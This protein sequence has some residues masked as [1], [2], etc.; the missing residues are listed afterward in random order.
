LPIDSHFVSQLE[1]K[2]E[3]TRLK[4][5]DSDS[6]ENLIPKT[7]QIESVLS[8][9]QK[10]QVKGLFESAV[11]NPDMEI[12]VEGMHPEELPVTITMDEF[13][14]RMKDMAK[15]GGGMMGMYGSFPDRYKVTVNG[16][17]KLIQ[18]LLAETDTTKQK[19]MARQAFDLALLSRNML[20]GEALTAFV[21]RSVGM[22]R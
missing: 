1:Q 7:E 17:H 14:R 20:T 2:L 6:T 8:D 4:R 19:D 21:N 13:M 9:E 10:E 5:V 22:M 3:K 12:T 15:T 16:N 11:Q 18:Q